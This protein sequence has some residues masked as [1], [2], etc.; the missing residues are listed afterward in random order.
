MSQSKENIEAKLAEYVEGT[1]DAAGRAEIEQHLAANPEHR[2]LMAD[3][4]ETR[5]VLRNLPRQPAPA[6]LTEMLQGQLE[7]AVLLDDGFDGGRS[8]R[9]GRWPQVLAVAAILLLAV[10][11]GVV[12]YVTLPPEHPSGFTIIEREVPGEIGVAAP[13]AVEDQ[14]GTRQPEVLAQRSTELPAAPAIADAMGESTVD[15]ARAETTPAA[16]PS[17]VAGLAG[18]ARGDQ[19]GGGRSVGRLPLAG[20][21]L[22]WLPEES[23]LAM[24]WLG[25]DVVVVMDGGDPQHVDQYVLSLFD[26]QNLQWE[27]IHQPVV[28]PAA[29]NLRTAPSASR[30]LE[31]QAEGAPA[32]REALAEQSD[33]LRRSAWQAEP[34]AIS[35]TATHQPTEAEDGQPA[36]LTGGQDQADAL[37]AVQNGYVVRGMTRQ[38]AEQLLALL[39]QDD[40]LRMN[41]VHNWARIATNTLTPQQQVMSDALPPA[42]TIDAPS[43]GLE[44]LKQDS[45]QVEPYAR[46][47]FDVRTAQADD[48]QPIRP[49]DTV[50]IQIDELV[51]PGVT[52]Q[53][54][55][56]IDETGQLKLQM[57]PV[58]VQA[59]GRR[60]AEL[61]Q[62]IADRYRE[63]HLI[64]NP[65]VRVRRAGATTQPA[66]EERVD[67]LILVQN[68]AV[69]EPV[70]SSEET[71]K[72]RVT[73]DASAAPDDPPSQPLPENQ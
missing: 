52:P 4:A 25:G 20:W 10:G 3:F 18:L 28:P 22:P 55:Q 26:Q 27:R 32:A 48:D 71:P 47:Y 61:E 35:G 30:D 68:R 56:T 39:S 50:E 73:P 63:S 8:L 13:Q 7:R 16:Q 70:K 14:A 46:Q 64:D 62:V 41:Q 2:R 33:T 6:D 69:T 59:E 11:L 24:G 57:I 37:V 15:S 29:V 12:V 38:Q 66:G 36:T 51:G 65:T 53:T 21:L 23:G 9:I 54:E 72:A 60:V 17:R 42:N 45:K 1:L 44:T 58:P 34:N 40:H 43:D 49:G 19:P 31:L 5:D 67:L